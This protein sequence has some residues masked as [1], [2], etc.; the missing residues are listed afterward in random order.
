MM[1]DARGVTLEVNAANMPN[2]RCSPRAYGYGETGIRPPLSREIHYTILSLRVCQPHTGSA[3]L[4]ERLTSI[5]SYVGL[6]EDECAI[7]AASFWAI[8][9]V[10]LDNR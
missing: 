4:Q 3:I 2:L 8:S 6:S 10:V 5:T 7:I 9:G 1:L